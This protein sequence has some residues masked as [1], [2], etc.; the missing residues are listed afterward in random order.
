VTERTLSGPARETEDAFRLLIDPYRE[1]LRL[2]CLRI[3][4]IVDRGGKRRRLRRQAEATRCS[5]RRSEPRIKRVR[6]IFRPIQ[7][8]TMVPDGDPRSLMLRV[9]SSYPAGVTGLADRSLDSARERSPASVRG[10]I[11][12][13]E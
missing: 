2:H 10:L 8:C 1:E 9:L 12:R 4:A 7:R 5:S 3:L 6:S 11:D 13:F